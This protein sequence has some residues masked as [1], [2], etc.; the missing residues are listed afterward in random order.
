MARVFISY[1]RSE[2][3]W[4]AGRLYDRLAEVI[5][6]EH[7]FFDV[8]DIEPGEDF[9][10]RIREIVGA[11]DVLIALIGPTWSA[12]QDGSGKPRLMNPRDLVRIEIASALQ[13][14]IRVIPILIDGAVMPEEHQ[15]PPDL[16][17]LLTRNAHDVSFKRF[18]ADLDSFIRVLHR[19]LALPGAAAAPGSPAPAPTPAPPVA[20]QLPFTISLTTLGGVSTPLIAKGARLPAQAS[21]V[22]STAADN[23]DSVEVNLSIGE[24][25][26]AG[27]NVPIGKFM[28]AGIPS[29]PRGTP[30]ITVTALV[31][32]AMILTVTAEDQATRKRQVLDA[33]DLT[34]ITVPPESLHGETRPP[35]PQESTRDSPVN[36]TDVFG[37]DKGRLTLGDL[38]D[39][40][41]GGPRDPDV[42]ST[43]TLSRAEAEAGGERHVTLREGHSVRVRIPAGIKDGQKLR[44]RGAGHAKE[45]GGSGDAYLTVRV[46]G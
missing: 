19:I 10:Q 38:L 44:F 1:R 46:K 13:R 36:F 20:T 4:A 8:S 35:A 15:L 3:R 33:V 24:R 42:H 5:G 23:Q 6:R 40:I 34:R 31:D 7:L 25:P 41:F 32:T 29:A 14:N 43:I 27:D 17:G 12:V 30:Q 11:C 28:L 18:H 22:F 21:E 2:S 16:A 9:V 37:G 45:G 26:L 39:R